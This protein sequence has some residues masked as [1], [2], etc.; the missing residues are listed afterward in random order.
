VLPW[1]FEPCLAAESK[2]G[3][4]G[5][6]NGVTFQYLCPL[7]AFCTSI[8]LPISYIKQI[9]VAWRPAFDSFVDMRRLSTD[10]Q[11]KSSTRGG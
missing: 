1:T 10:A 3:Q 8:S 6:L 9:N 4:H 7:F 2:L 5:G 11:R